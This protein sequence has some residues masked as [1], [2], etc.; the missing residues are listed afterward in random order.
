MAWTYR[1]ADRGHASG[2]WVDTATGAESATDPTGGAGA[3]AGGSGSDLE[4]TTSDGLVRNQPVGGGTGIF[5]SGS[6]PDGSVTPAAPNFSGSV[7]K[8]TEAS[9]NL[10]AQLLGQYTNYQGQAAPN[11]GYSQIA[12]VS[13]AAPVSW[14]PVA[15]SQVGQVAA[16]SQVAP[17]SFGGPMSA[18]ASSSGSAAQAIAALADPATT[19]AGATVDKTDSNEVRARQ[20]SLADALTSVMNGGG[21]QSPAA[22]QL[23]MGLDQALQQ[24]AA[25]AASSRGQNVGLGQYNAAIQGGQLAGQANQQAAMLKAQE[26]AQARSQL[27]ALLNNTRGADIGL[28]ENQA[29]LTNT[30]GMFSAGQI[31]QGNQFNA[32]QKNNVGMFNADQ[33]NQNQRLDAQLGTQASI[34]SMTS[35][36]AYNAQMN[37]LAQA[38]AIQNGQWNQDTNLSNAQLGQQNSQFNAGQAN[39]YDQALA[40]ALQQ[41]NQFNTGQTNTYNQNQASMNQGVNLANLGA[42]LQTQGLNQQ[43]QNAIL[44]AL[45]TGN[46]QLLGTDAAIYGTNVGANTQMSI[47]QMQA[48]LAKYLQN[49]KID[50]ANSFHWKDLFNAGTAAL[51]T[52]LGS[53]AAPATG[54]S[55]TIYGANGSPILD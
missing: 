34:A 6:G 54:A 15:T 50:D 13:T 19:Y 8:D 53:P 30:A 27:D 16:A 45:L 41:N 40:A 2:Y 43:G 52:Y 28:A 5:A 29:G 9:R 38:L 1:P 4:V 49:Q 48:D 23:Q 47:A 21:P 55:K 35:G 37:Q 33:S 14:A 25:I 44:A 12:P 42:Q 32:G 11:A 51:G 39:T 20:L 3:S 10:L 7:D 17:M 24:Q 22:V 36:N 18:G 46:G 31:N 26:T